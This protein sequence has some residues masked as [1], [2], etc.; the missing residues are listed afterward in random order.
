MS[1]KTSLFIWIFLIILIAFF[2]G[3]APAQKP[4]VIGGSLPLTGVWAET[5]KVIQKGYEF[6]V[7][8]T[9]AQGGLLGRPIKLIIYD[10][11]GKPDSAV[12]LAEKAIT[13]DK[14]NLL[15][16][17]YPGTAARAVMPVAEKHKMVYV[18][19]GGHMASFTQGYTYSFG[20]P[21]LMG[22]W[23]FLGAFQWLETFPPDQRPKRAAVYIMNN[24]VGTSLLP[25][26]DEY[27]KKIGIQVVI[28]ERYNLPL[29]SAEP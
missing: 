4:I 22:E 8:E 3:N 16:G 29:P 7:E 14:V 10:D 24:P 5:A 28:N 25:S 15:L 1:R 21:P 2:P 19:M 23:W 6:W 12:K 13:V 20:S 11:E 9:N 17:G 18:S 27:T 26:I